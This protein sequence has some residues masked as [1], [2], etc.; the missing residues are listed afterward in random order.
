MDQALHRAVDQVDLL[1]PRPIDRFQRLQEAAK[2]EPVRFLGVDQAQTKFAEEHIEDFRMGLLV[3]KYKAH[4]LKGREQ[5]QR[6]F[7]MMG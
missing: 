6:K 1:N 7:L 2:H 3:C 4:D 5:S